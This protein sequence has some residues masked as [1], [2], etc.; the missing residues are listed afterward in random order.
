VAEKKVYLGS[1]GP[2]LYDDT[3]LLDDADSELPGEYYSGVATTGNIVATEFH[4]IP[5]TSISVT[6]IDDPSTELNPLSASTVGGLIAV[7]QA[8][9][10]ADDEFTMYLWDT[11]AAAENV[12][13]TVDGDG[14]VWIAVSG[15]YQ[16][17]EFNVEGPISFGGPTNYASFATDGELTLHGTARVTK[18]FTIDAINLDKGLQGP[19]A[20]I[21]GHSIGYSYD[22]GDDSVMNFEVPYDCDTSED[23]K[24]E[25]YWY[26]DEARTGS[27][28]EVQWRA[29]WSACPANGTEAIDA[30]THTG[31]IDFGDQLIPGTAK[32]LTEVSGLIAA[33]SISDG[34]FISMTL[35][36]VALDDG[37]SPTADPV[38]VQIEVEY[39]VNKLGE[40]T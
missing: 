7:Y 17:G 25:I 34:D 10:A 33:A 22:I 15:K 12:P 1:Q 30:P 23:L 26:I 18:E 39:I 27:N 11:N 4:G 32:Y 38:I 5:V 8:V 28:E 21:L 3:D 14:G 40:A 19:D 36:R 20:V 2:Y 6:D 9:G 31:T 24:V 35:D 16:N 13:Y 37:N 29:Q